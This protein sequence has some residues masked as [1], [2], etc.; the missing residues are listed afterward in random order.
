MIK[1]ILANKPEHIIYVSCNP[2]TLA[3]NLNEL[4]TAYKIIKIKPY[5][6]FAQTCHVETLVIMAKKG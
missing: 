2:S 5:D 4:K 6:M 3:K 1:D